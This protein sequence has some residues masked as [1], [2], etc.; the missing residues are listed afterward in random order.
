MLKGVYIILFCGYSNGEVVWCV[1][2]DRS[3]GS[4]TGAEEH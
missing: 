4:V 1:W 2:C 3:W